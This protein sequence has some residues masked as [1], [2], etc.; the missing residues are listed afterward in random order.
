MHSTSF[1]I[2]KDSGAEVH[3]G[4]GITGGTTLT[5]A[6]FGSIDYDIVDDLTLI[7]QVAAGSP[8]GRA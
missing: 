4:I 8:P 3:N 2:V 7:D 6:V 5:T 1:E